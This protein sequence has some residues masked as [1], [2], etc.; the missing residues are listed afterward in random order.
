MSE[1]LTY[2]MFGGT[3]LGAV[4]HKGVIPWDNDIDVAMPRKD[5]E[6]LEPVLKRNLSSHLRVQSWRTDKTGNSMILRIRN[7]NTIC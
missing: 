6:K 4:R 1:G 3:L 5:F 7:M 2:V